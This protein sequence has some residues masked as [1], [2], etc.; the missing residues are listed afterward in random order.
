MNSGSSALSVANS[1]MTTSSRGS[2]SA[3]ALAQVVGQVDGAGVAQHPLAVLELGL[4]AAQRPLGQVLVEVGDHA[5]GVRQPG[6]LVEGAAALEVDEH[7]REVVGIDAGGQAGHQRAQQLGLA[8][9]GGAADEARGARRPRSRSRT[10][11]PRPRRSGRRAAGRGRAAFHR[12][13]TASG[14]HSSRSSSGSSRIDGGQPGADQVE[15]G[16]LEPGQRP[17]AVAGDVVGHAGRRGSRAMRSPRWGRRRSA[18]PSGSVIST[19]V[20][21]T[22]GSRSA[23]EAID[24]AGHRPGLAPQQVAGRRLAALGQ[25]LVVDHDE[26][27]RADR[28]A[29]PAARRSARSRAAAPALSRASTRRV[30]SS[31]SCDSMRPDAAG[32]AGVG[33]PLGPV[34]RRPRPRRRPGPS[35]AGRPGRGGPPPGTRS[36]RASGQ[37]RRPV[38]DDADH[39]APRQVDAAPGRRRSVDASSSSVAPAPPACRP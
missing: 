2:G 28:P 6:A 15:L 5:D 36:D 20:V 38:A 30:D 29:R 23:V 32:V 14:V 34:P 39:P 22:A 31:G 3:Q 33:Q 4:E 21:H 7:E 10:R 17:G 11:R 8:G 9:A 27:R 26:Q 13:S 25:R 24:D 35:S 12:A 1:S 16:V 37:G 19:T 18:P